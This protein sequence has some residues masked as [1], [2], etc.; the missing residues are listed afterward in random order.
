[1]FPSLSADF[2]K[3][4]STASP[5]PA[6]LTSKE[7][8]EVLKSVDKI[9]VAD[10]SDERMAGRKVGIIICKVQLTLMDIFKHSSNNLATLQLEMLLSECQ[11]TNYSDIKWSVLETRKIS[12]KKGHIWPYTVDDK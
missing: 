12:M 1:M 5:L 4:F 3:L 11:K 9:L 10:W 7:I 2:Q 6:T 8:E